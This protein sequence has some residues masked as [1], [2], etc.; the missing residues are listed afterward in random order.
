[1]LDYIDNQINIPIN[2][3]NV[4]HIKVIKKKKIITG[5]RKIKKET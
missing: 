5:I 4:Q 3:T 1:M 2:N